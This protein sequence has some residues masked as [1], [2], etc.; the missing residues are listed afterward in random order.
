MGGRA[1][2]DCRCRPRLA[3]ARIPNQRHV[4]NTALDMTQN[5]PRP[6]PPEVIS[7]IERELTVPL[8]DVLYQ[9][10]DG[11]CDELRKRN[12]AAEAGVARGDLA[13]RAV[14]EAVNDTADGNRPWQLG[15][16]SLGHHLAAIVVEWVV[17]EV[18]RHQRREEVRRSA[19][20][21]EDKR[22]YFQL[23]S[24]MGD[25][26][27]FKDPLRPLD[28]ELVADYEALTPAIIDR[29]AVLALRET[30]V[31]ALAQIRELHS[32]DA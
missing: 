12:P 23:D 15:E 4:R 20:S 3:Q 14:Y 26:V 22:S 25:L 7:R 10:A 2:R 11:A 27:R 1:K 16:G 19:R 17:F 28:K 6:V 30:C 24:V 13:A 18:F 21:D 32:I 31:N 9:F 8:L 5:R 29:P